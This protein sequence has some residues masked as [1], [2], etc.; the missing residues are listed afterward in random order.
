MVPLVVVTA[1]ALE[2]DVSDVGEQMAV[3]A[4]MG[5]VAAFSLP[6]VLEVLQLC[7]C[8]VLSVMGNLFFVQLKSSSK[9]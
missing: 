5:V 8:L 9:V 6:L 7:S 2:G 4:E 3:V 1:P